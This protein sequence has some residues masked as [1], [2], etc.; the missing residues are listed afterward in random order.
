[1]V[2]KT[3]LRINQIAI[4]AV[5]ALAFVL[6]RSLGGG[7]LLLALAVA[8]AI[9]AARPSA[10]PLRHLYLRVL[11]PLGIARP[12][13]VADDPAPHR[14]AQGVG[15]VFLFGAAGSLLGGAVLLGWALAWIVVALALTNLLTGFCAGC[16]MYVQLER[17]GLLPHGRGRTA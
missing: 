5:V 4:T 8:L 14:F 7:W 13:M 12:E 9:G 11:R 16:F 1:M 15:A 17:A 3:M 10:S 2:D 6:G